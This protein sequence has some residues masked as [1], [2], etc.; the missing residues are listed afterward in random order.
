MSLDDYIKA[1][2]PFPD[3]E[4]FLKVSADTGLPVTEE[5]EEREDDDEG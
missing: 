5:E 2:R 3:E 4:L 1:A